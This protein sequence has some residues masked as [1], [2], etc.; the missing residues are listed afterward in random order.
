M[1]DRSEHRAQNLTAAL[2]FLRVPPTA[3]ELRLLHRWLD[4]WTGIGLI[5]VDVERQG[6]RL[7]LS[8]ITEGEWRAR[9]MATP[10]GRRPAS[11]WWRRRGARCRWRGGR[12]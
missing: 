12:R 4:T 1:V 6:Y 5:T 2:G 11:A 3:P 9:F 7:M 8:H 10:G